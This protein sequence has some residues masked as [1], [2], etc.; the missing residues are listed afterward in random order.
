MIRYS[1]IALIALLWCHA[2]PARDA[3]AHLEKRGDTTRLVVDGSPF[4]MLAGELGNSSA[5]TAEY[6]ERV[7]PEL[8]AMNLN[9]VLA[10]VYWELI[11]PREGEFDFS[12]VDRL[13]DEA[14]DHDLKLV[15]LWF[16]TWKNSMSSHAP[17]W[18]KLDQHR[19][20]RV[21][22]DKGVSHEILTPFSENNLQADRR[23][24]V[25]L[26]RH[27]KKYDAKRQT[28]IM[29][30]VENEIGM[31]PSARDHYP[32]AEKAYRASVPAGLMQYLE[33][34]GDRL[35]PELASHWAAQGGA[36][37]G[38]WETV[39]GKGA[40]TDEIFMAWHFARFT[41][42]LV[43][44]GKAVYPLPMFVNAALSRPGEKPGPDYPSGGPLPHLMDIWKAAAPAIDFLSP[45]F[46]TP[47]FKHWNDL[48]TRQGNPLFIPEHRFDDTVAAKAAFAF[49]HYEA[50]G[51]APFSIETGSQENGAAL[52]AMYD[53]LG[54]LSPVITRHQ[55][56]GRIEGVLLDEGRET[57]FRMGGYEFTCRHDYTL[58][59]SP[60]AKK[61]GWP[62]AGAVIVHTGD[63]EFYVAGTGVVITFRP[64]GNAAARAGLLKVD[65]GTFKD[66]AWRVR[67]HLNGDQTH[68]GR[69][70][71]IPMGRYSIQ[72]VELYTY[73]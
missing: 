38:D 1:A 40:Y 17:A 19:F 71:R 12:R 44:A 66:G 9:T 8:K 11:E 60:E 63:N 41:N 70:V 30:Q 29:V 7:W 3:I 22:D 68:Q 31:L 27:L 24:F 25:Q 23:A 33:R 73:E 26:M 5:S 62:A 54:Q 67:R 55:G 18:V 47:R 48:Y 37:E 53:V 64:A 15:L 28:V 57:V 50:M 39:F 34:N 52:A 2:A 32:L 6:M 20:P 49:G 13:I 51:F 42:E 21:K 45:D 14:R 43:E 10:P 46:Y 59:W 4:L 35:V 69:H 65:E 36:T 72:R 58:G 56:Q 16:A 61:P